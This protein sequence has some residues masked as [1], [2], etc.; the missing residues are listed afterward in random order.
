MACFT[1][2]G[3]L[4]GQRRI[5]AT[6]IIQAGDEVLREQPALVAP[7]RIEITAFE[8]PHCLKLRPKFRHGV[9]SGVDGVPSISGDA[10]VS[11]CSEECASMHQQMHNAE[12]NILKPMLKLIS[13]VQLALPRAL[14]LLRCLLAAHG[15][16][17]G[18]EG[19]SSLHFLQWLE[20][21]VQEEPQIPLDVGD[22]M[23][24]PT[25]SRMPVEPD[26][27]ERLATLFNEHMSVVPRGHWSEKHVP[28]PE[29]VGITAL[30]VQR[31][32]SRINSYAF[33]CASGDIT[34]N[35]DGA[36]SALF[37]FASFFNHSCAP[38]AVTHWDPKTGELTV[39]AVAPMVRGDEITISYIPHG[40]TFECSQC[41]GTDDDKGQRTVVNTGPQHYPR[42]E[43]QDRRDYLFSSRFFLC[44][45]PRCVE[46]QGTRLG[47][48]PSLE[49]HWKVMS[50]QFKET[51]PQL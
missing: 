10:A 3:D 47:K 16:A 25:A 40:C 51:K 43:Q 26:V 2:E 50:W 14:L 24:A 32:L 37:R 1:V 8:C 17:G 44:N 20:H 28:A 35:T 45:C 33:S 27:A 21:H 9:W 30:E 11:F 19:S 4:A 18:Y 29:T 6:R 46:E 5:V 36:G 31:W 15:C 22:G 7:S 41:L 39:T 38:N 49:E 12:S 23:D 48:P 13:E 34:D 42:M